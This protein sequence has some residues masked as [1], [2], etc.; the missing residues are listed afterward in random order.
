MK[1]FPILATLLIAVSI[2]STARGQD[3]A[4]ATAWKS[5]KLGP[6]FMPGIS[7]NAGSVANGT[8]TTAVNFSWSLGAMADFPFSPN[9]GLQLGVGY[10]SRGVEFHDQKS[11]DTSIAYT[12]SYFSLRPEFRIG[13]FL[14]GLGIGIPV[15]AST[16]ASSDASKMNQQQSLGAS[17]LNT[18]IEGRIGAAIP[19]M[20]SDNG[21]ELKFLIDASYAFSQISSNPLKPNDNT[22]NKTDNNGPLATLQLGFA[23]LFNLN[24]K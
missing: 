17:G 5:V 10:D 14:V 18:L 12:L 1:K 24:P 22:P 4:A 8:K 13:D 9:L 7:S 3:S 2:S 15:G 19:V 16:T 21:N 11:A 23:Y 20:E 6:M